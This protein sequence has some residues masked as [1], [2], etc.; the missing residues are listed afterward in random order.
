[1]KKRIGRLVS[2]A[3]AALLVLGTCVFSASAQEF[4]VT[5]LIPDGVTLH[6]GS[7]GDTLSGWTSYSAD[8]NTMKNTTI[9]GETVL[10]FHRNVEG[11]ARG[12]FNF[13]AITGDFIIQTRIQKSNVN[14]RLEIFDIN[15][16]TL[17]YV[18]LDSIHSRININVG[19]GTSSNTNLFFPLDN[20]EQWNIVTLHFHAGRATFDSYLNGT[21]LTS[22]QPLRNMVSMTGTASVRISALDA[23]GTASMDYVR[24]YTI[25]PKINTAPVADGAEIS[26]L[27]SSGRTLTVNY[28]FS[29]ADGDIEGQTEFIWYYSDSEN[30]SYLPISG[31]TAK[32]FT[33]TPAYAGKYLKCIV[34]P[35]DIFGNKGNSI[36]TAPVHELSIITDL[37]RSSF[38]TEDGQGWS[39]TPGSDMSSTRYAAID[40]VNGILKIYSSDDTSTAVTTA[41]RTIE[42]SSLTGDLYLD[43]EV[44]ID[45]NFT[46]SDP[47]SIFLVKMQQDGYDAVALNYYKNNNEPTLRLNMNTDK[48]Q[49]VLPID[50]WTRMG[51]LINTSNKTVSFFVNGKLMISNVRYEN[52]SKISDAKGI[53][54]LQFGACRN[55]ASATM[56]LQY[57]NISFVHVE[58]Y[59]TEPVAANVSVNGIAN[60]GQTITGNYSFSDPDG[61]SE[62]STTYQWYIAGSST[63]DFSPIESEAGKTLS[64]HAGMAN[65][66]IKLGVTPV[67]I[68]GKAGAESLSEPI[69][70]RAVTEEKLNETYNSG[71][72][73]DN[74]AGYQLRSGEDGQCAIAWEENSINISNTSITTDARY[75]KSL[76]NDLS[77]PFCLELSL[78]N[79]GGSSSINIPNGEAAIIE[80]SGTTLKVLHLAG[81]QT[82]TSSY[83]PS[84]SYRFRFVFRSLSGVKENDIFDL[85]VD[86]VYYGAYNCRKDNLTAITGFNIYKT[87]DS[88]D[89]KL[90]IDDVLVYNINP[91]EIFEDIVAKWVYKDG[92]GQSSDMP[93]AGG[94][95]EL[96]LK[97]V[98]EL[99]SESA[100]LVPCLM[101]GDALLT[102][103][104]ENVTANELSDGVTVSLSI[105]ENISGDFGLQAF[106]WESLESLKPLIKPIA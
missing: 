34:T 35:V 53:T 59:N 25:S 50:D 83:D 26:G 67:D 79:S 85:F 86:D 58:A 4:N 77:A 93:V 104:V 81:S 33:L 22:E 37:Y 103:A 99:S 18:D 105:P 10:Q 46:Q 80:F 5:E 75:L 19:T 14:T 39:F 23:I 42:N 2:A 96:Q 45:P 41:T 73:E 95:A 74:L 94:T 16:T 8:G 29:D 48:Y 92:A 61:D 71:T 64:L 36:E 102:T 27:P 55:G 7:E 3:V 68:Y 32:T 87:K 47:R 90:F 12:G 57:R 44:K 63:A 54:A 78:K 51:L 82:I 30:G 91:T 89:G 11:N 15:S 56:D 76:S 43:F 88:G 70:V 65:A 69:L 60:V 1:M 101:S 28:N 17:S 24:I 100:V 52:E 40:N 21:R 20:S 62:G 106:L 66:Y 98:R 38:S 49:T 13:E 97:V 31:A 9:D 84:H 72:A 6:A